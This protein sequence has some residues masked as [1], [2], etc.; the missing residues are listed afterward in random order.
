MAKNDAYRDLSNVNRIVIKIGTS[1]LTDEKYRLDPRKVK[2]FTDEI[3]ELRKK[4]K[5]VIVVTSGAIGAGI[6]R[7][8]L[9]T[10]PKE[11]QWLQAAAAVG[12]NI[13]MNTYDKYFS[14]H[15]Q[16]VAQLLLTYEDF[17]NEHRYLNLRNTLTTLLKSG[18]IPI[19]N[20]NDTTAVDEIKVGDNDKLSALVASNLDADLLIILS[21]IDGL[22]TRDPK[23]SEEAELISTVRE[24]T[25]ELESICGNESSR[26]TGGMMTK[27]QAAKI[28]MEKGIPMII[29][30]GGE[31]SIIK[32]IMNGE[33]I[34]TIFLPK[35]GVKNRHQNDTQIVETGSHKILEMAQAARKAA[36]EL[37]NTPTEVKNR[38]L[39]KMAE[40]IRQNKSRILE[41]NREDVENAKKENLSKAL[42]DRLKL[43]D[44]KIEDIIRSLESVAKLED[45]VGKTLSAI[46]LDDGLKLFQVTCPIGVIGAIFESRPDAL[47]QI[48]SL[49][50]KSGNAVILKGG[51]EAKKSN[52][53]LF[54]ILKSSS[55]DLPEGWIQLA[56][57]R[58]DVK[59]MLKM[60]KYIDLLVPRGSNKFVKYIQENT[61][62]PVLGHSEG[63][64]HIYVDREADL[65]MAANICYDAKVQY[66]AACNSVET[67]LVDKPIAEVFLPMVAERLTN[68]GVKLKGCE[69]TIKMLKHFK[70][71]EVKDWHVE[72]SDLIV[73]IKIVDGVDEAISHINTYGSKHTDA[74]VTNNNET[75]RKFLNFVDSSSVM[76]NAS[77]R[78]SDGFRYGKGAEVGISTNKIHA[79][80]PVG[81]EGLVIYKYLLFGKGHIVADY[82]GPQ[83]KRFTHK[84]LNIQN[85]PI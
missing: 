57:T 23:T 26:G 77:T 75:A 12:Q 48:A 34:G 39:L 64:C 80:G 32:R 30:N 14:K 54:E 45:P 65:E 81:L 50:L 2:R 83:A 37:A 6:G 78:F 46:E 76:H 51:S 33:P 9:K 52:A 38:A 43:D 1:S 19:I 24:I 73:S 8:N 15:K 17:S 60:D 79:R 36:I 85:K 28:T 41:A 53:V 13:L 16:T 29:A 69:E 40:A 70:V 61:N 72:Y 11:I 31:K 63:I 21:D 55:Q 44:S 84:K 18:V 49:C 56:E 82:I 74:I 7:L 3:M 35:N 5:E 4:K 71:E 58:E 22:Y 10:R 66:P 20:E 27:I 42:V 68:A 25:P 59:S 67:I 62:I 47:V